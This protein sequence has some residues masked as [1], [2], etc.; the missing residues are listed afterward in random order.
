MFKLLPNAIEMNKKIRGKIGRNKS[1][2]IQQTVKPTEK[3]TP[4]KA[5]K[6]KAAEDRT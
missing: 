2:N 5:Q 4:K 1:Y 3:K 6:R